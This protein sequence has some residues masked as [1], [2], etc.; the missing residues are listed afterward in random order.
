MPPQPRF[1]R[2]QL[3]QAALGRGGGGAGGAGLVQ[4]MQ[5]FM[6]AMGKSM[7]QFVRGA[8]QAQAQQAEQT[9][10]AVAQVADAAQRAVNQAEQKAETRRQET[11][12]EALT[13]G[14]R[15][16]RLESMDYERALM[17]KVQREGAELASIIQEM[18]SKK[19]RSLDDQERGAATIAEST[20]SAIDFVHD[21]D[22]AH[23][24]GR[25]GKP[26][27][28]DYGWKVRQQM[29]DLARMSQVVREDML[30][31]PYADKLHAMVA[32]ASQALIRGDSTYA[33]PTGTFEQPMLP[34][35]AAMLEALKLDLPTLTPEEAREWELYNGYPK[36]GVWKMSMDDPK[37]VMVNPVSFKA[38][39]KAKQDDLMLAVMQS[40][41]SRREYHLGVAKD[42]L[43]AQ[44]MNEPLERMYNEY[45]DTVT[46]VLP[47]AIVNTLVPNPR[48]WEQTGATPE[49]VVRQIYSTVLEGTRASKET[50]DHA[51]RLGL[52]DDDPNRWAPGIRKDGESD[53]DFQ[54]RMAEDMYDTIP[55]HALA[56]QMQ[57]ILT[58]ATTDPTFRGNVGAWLG[59]LRR[60]QL[61]ESGVDPE[62]ATDITRA[63]HRVSQ[64]QPLHVFEGK[65]TAEEQMEIPP[66]LAEAAVSQ[67]ISKWTKWHRWQMLLPIK[68]NT[69]MRTWQENNHAIS[70]LSD[71]HATS[72]LSV[73]EPKDLAD[74]V[75]SGLIPAETAEAVRTGET[76]MFRAPMG[77]L[78][79]IVALHN[80]PGARR[81]LREYYKAGSGDD[82]LRT[83]PE[84][85]SEFNTVRAHHQDAAKHGITNPFTAIPEFNERTQLYESPIGTT[86]ALPARK[87]RKQSIQRFTDRVLESRARSQA[88]QA[89]PQPPKIGQA[90]TPEQPPAQP[91]PQPTTQPQPGGAAQL[92][93]MQVEGGGPQQ[94]Q[95]PQQPQRPQAQPGPF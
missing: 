77:V 47:D 18:E 88:V 19:Q 40:E 76:K 53:A 54:V 69:I 30:D 10:A 20:E 2:Q 11:R 49:E 35:P 74:M 64:R 25:L 24:W 1:D 85:D 66:E 79:S 70:V 92:S 89:A 17:S 15:Q 21:L 32:Q 28:P 78:Q 56:T 93:P 58:G 45:G 38:I 67:V 61:I 81:G 59:S 80:R 9:Q 27:D 72:V 7:N 22:A 39:T 16:F 75:E 51:L 65:P 68:N 91:P 86:T 84:R 83:D 82:P 3:V 13:E 57:E 31:S 37:F 44:E 33:E 95:Q 41:E 73:L 62:T 87:E 5:A 48:K 23:A 14:G 4:A 50:T 55:M 29:L 71:G 90:G 8:T 46:A 26:D 43:E 60:E 34:I 6:E 12:Q 36:G 94:P 42:V 63:R 52:P